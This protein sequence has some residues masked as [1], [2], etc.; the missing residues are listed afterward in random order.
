M[1]RADGIGDDVDPHPERDGP[2]GI[3]SAPPPP[4]V[5]PPPP[6]S[7]PPPTG[8][9][10][11]TDFAAAAAMAKDILSVGPIPASESTGPEVETEFE[12]DHQQL[13]VTSPPEAPLASD[14]FTPARPKKRFWRSR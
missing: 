12:F 5:A 10:S 6:P 14:F 11:T 3:C 8:L 9:S 4:P 7:G 13:A 1:P 2:E